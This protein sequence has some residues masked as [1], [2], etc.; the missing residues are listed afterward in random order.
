MANIK[1]S[2]KRDEKSK[3]LR[4]KNRA[5][6][7]ELKTMIKKFDAAVVDG[8]REAAESAYKV[9]V[10][11]VDRAAGKGLLHKNN[12]AHK[13]SAMATKLNEMA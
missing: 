5:D 13:K 1:S 3:E 4:A 9:A 8:N 10:K 11:T 7:T 6:K 2:A 12:A